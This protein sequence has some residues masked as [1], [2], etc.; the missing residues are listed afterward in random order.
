MLSTR[1]TVRAVE[2]IEQAIE[3]TATM[4][5]KINELRLLATEQLT[6]VEEMD[7][8]LQSEF[9]AQVLSVHTDVMLHAGLTYASLNLL[10]SALD[11]LNTSIGG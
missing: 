9:S 11:R 10:V 8:L 3:N 5:A 6:F 1:A 7:F 4:Y 2:N